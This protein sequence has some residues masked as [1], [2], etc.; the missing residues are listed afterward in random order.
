MLKFNF[1]GTE[2]TNLLIDFNK[3]TLTSFTNVSATSLKVT[4]KLYLNNPQR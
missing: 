3:I 2:S 1:I 4:Q